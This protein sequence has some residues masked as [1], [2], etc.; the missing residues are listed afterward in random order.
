MKLPIFSITTLVKFLSP[1]IKKAAKTS[2]WSSG[3]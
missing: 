1:F 2:A 3:L